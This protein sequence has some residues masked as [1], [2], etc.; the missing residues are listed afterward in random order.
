M[1]CV[2]FIK[3]STVISEIPIVPLF[4]QIQLDFIQ[5]I[6][7]HRMNLSRGFTL[8]ILILDV[9]KGKRFNIGARKRF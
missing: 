6:L 4:S 8:Q 2:K 5:C 7:I 1:P 9:Q 3:F